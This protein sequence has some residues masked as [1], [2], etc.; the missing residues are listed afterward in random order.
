[1]KHPHY[2]T[3][4]ASRVTRRLEKNICQIFQRVAKIVAK[5]KKIYIKAQFETLKHLHQ[6]TLETLKCLQQTMF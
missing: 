1:M 5:P 4:E 3:P 6:T 2:V